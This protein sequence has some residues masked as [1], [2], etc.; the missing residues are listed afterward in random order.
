MIRRL[1]VLFALIS[2]ALVTPALAAPVAS[3]SAIH[4]NKKD[5]DSF[6][7]ELKASGPYKKG[8]EGTVELVLKSKGGH[9]VNQDY[10]AKFKVADPAPEGITFPKKILKKEDGKFEE[11]EA[12]LKIP[13]VAANAG[14]AKIGGTFSFSVCSDKNCFM[15]KADLEVEV[16]VK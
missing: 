11:H 12:T 7:V 9:H 10:P 6:T 16:D 3:S 4:A 1:S 8:V 5:K 2:A 15:E 14:K 13:F